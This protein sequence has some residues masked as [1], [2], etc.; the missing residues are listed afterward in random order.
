VNQHTKTI[1][2][3]L[4]LTPKQSQTL[5]YQASLCRHIFNWA[6]ARRSEVYKQTKKG[7]T[8]NQQSAEMTTYKQANRWLYDAP[9]DSLQHALKDVER[10]FKNFF[11]NVQNIPALRLKV[12]PCQHCAIP[13]TVFWSPTALNFPSSGGLGASIPTSTFY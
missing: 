4:R 13:K 5:A 6:L 2:V 8:Y 10:A 3:K 1:K 7:L 12:E 11:E 9:A